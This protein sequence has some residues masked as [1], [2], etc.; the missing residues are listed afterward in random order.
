MTSRYTKR[1]KTVFLTTRNAL[2]S[3]ADDNIRSEDVAQAR[4]TKRKFNSGSGLIQLNL[5]RVLEDTHKFF[6]PIEEDPERFYQCICLVEPDGDR[7]YC[8]AQEKTLTTNEW[9]YRIVMIRR[10]ATRVVVGTSKPDPN[11]LNIIGIFHFDNSAFTVLERPG[12]SLPE[13]AVCHSPELGLAQI[14]TISKEVRC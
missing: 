5:P 14:Q 9:P 2:G 6:T 11:L 12:L 7:P 10:S 3:D 4:G 1:R 8:L 13:V